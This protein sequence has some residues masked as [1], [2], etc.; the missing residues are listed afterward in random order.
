MTYEQ[1]IDKFGS[2]MMV[3]KALGM[4]TDKTYPKNKRKITSRICMWKKQ[5]I[6]RKVQNLISFM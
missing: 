2:P 1:L 6:P 4:V 5:G 3:A